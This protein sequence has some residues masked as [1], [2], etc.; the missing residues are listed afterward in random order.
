MNCHRDSQVIFR[1]IWTKTTK[2]LVCPLCTGLW[3][4]MASLR[5]RIRFEFSSGKSDWPRGS[6]R[7]A[8]QVKHSL[9]RDRGKNPKIKGFYLAK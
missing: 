8:L 5:R 4:A 1:K 6:Q 2:P 3:T 9:T 7:N